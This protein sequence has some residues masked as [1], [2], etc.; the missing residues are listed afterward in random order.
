MNI[1][2]VEVC[3]NDEEDYIIFDVITPIGWLGI[4]GLL[5]KEKVDTIVISNREWKECQEHYSKQ[6]SF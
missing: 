4:N 6:G 5:S 1:K 2:I 3:E